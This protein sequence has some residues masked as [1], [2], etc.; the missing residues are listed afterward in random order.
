[1]EDVYKRQ[2]T[3]LYPFERVGAVLRDQKIRD[4]VVADQIPLRCV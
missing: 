2:D 4:D 1:M 3:T